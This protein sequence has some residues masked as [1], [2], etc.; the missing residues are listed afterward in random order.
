LLDDEAV[1]AG[2]RRGRELFEQKYNLAVGLRTLLGVY[3]EVRSRHAHVGGT[4]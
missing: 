3:E 1:D 2:G 4:G